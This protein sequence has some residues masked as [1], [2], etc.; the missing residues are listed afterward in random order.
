[1]AEPGAEK[2]AAAQRG[3]PL[4][5]PPIKVE[6]ADKFGEEG[7]HLTLNEAAERLT[8][9]RREQAAKREQE[10]AEFTG[11]LAARQQESSEAGWRRSVTIRLPGLSVSRS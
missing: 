5:P 6:I 7:K 2:I 3:D 1:L 9:W 4:D 10:L 8:A 11:E